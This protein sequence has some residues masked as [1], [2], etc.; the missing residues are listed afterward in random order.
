[1]RDAECRG[2]S[3][4]STVSSLKRAHFVPVSSQSSRALTNLHTLSKAL[5]AWL[6]GYSWRRVPVPRPAKLRV[7]VADRDGFDI[8]LMAYCLSGSEGWKEGAIP[9]LR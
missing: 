6:C 9:Q 7:I 4:G 1:M 8:P 2:Q 5:C 3:L